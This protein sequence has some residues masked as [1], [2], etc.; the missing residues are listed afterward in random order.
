M[1]KIFYL[2]LLFLPLSSIAQQTDSAWMVKHYVK[3]ERYIRMRDGVKLFVSIY[4][5]KDTTEK[6]HPIMLLR[7]PYSCA[8]YG[9]EWLPF[10]NTYLT[11][12]FK[13][14]YDIVLEDVRGR[15]LSEGEFVNIRPFIPD[16]KTN[17]DIDEASDAYD[18]IDW[19]V[20][21]VAG[22]NNRVGAMGTSYPG[23]YTTMAALSGHPALKA[24]SPQA[25][26]TEWFIGDDIHHNGA[27]MLMDMVDFYIDW[28]FG[29]PRPAPTILNPEPLTHN[30]DDSYTYFLRAGA[31][32]YFTKIANK[33]IDAFWGEVMDHPNYDA[34]WTARNDRN[35]AAM[36]PAGTATLVVGG[37]FDAE[38]CFG[39]INLYKAIEHKAKN[40]NKFVFGPWYHGQW[41]NGD[42]THLG[43]VQF[44]SN[45]AKWYE[46]NIELPFFNY[47]LK[48]EGTPDSISEATV[49]FTGENKWHKLPQWP[50]AGIEPT[51]IYLHKGGKL[52]FSKPTAANSF[53]EYVSD[54]AKPVPYE[55][56]VRNDR[57]REY[58]DDD[59]RFA[60]TRTDVLTFET[61][62]LASDV[63]LAGPLTA[64]LE[65]SLS[66]TDADFV[67]KLIDVFPDDFKYPGPG[68]DDYIMNSYQMMVRGDIFRGRYRNSFA[69]P[70]AFV[71]G[72]VTEVKYTLNDIAHTFK[73]GHRIMVQI[74]SSWFPLADRN[75][76][77]FVDTYHAKDADFI[78]SN[79]RVY[80]S[81]N[82]ASKI[83]LPVLK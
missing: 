78:K 14:G 21:N 77:Q 71:P 40:N 7:T 75:P 79:I 67:V 1:R 23:F 41:G 76:Q 5:S 64:D 54:P 56:G 63:T 6:T 30:T 65:V 9:K 17:K 26:V 36:I 24:A 48:G 15:Y 47:Y 46:E 45:T 19:L 43:H 74:Q 44:G 39:A 52:S 2:L 28:G 53:E 59:Q 3:K 11:Q 66:T 18:T 50:P 58:M 81:A 62:T 38:D 22:N 80:L 49:F 25:P 10:W 33:R 35:Y 83:I 68:N 16:K 13:A 34:Y 8:P 57:T 20:K 12:Y 70:E 60:S 55:D 4:M 32:P 29:V 82:A 61:D 73:K 42:G 31:L 37:L 69:K 27:F 51:D 72:K